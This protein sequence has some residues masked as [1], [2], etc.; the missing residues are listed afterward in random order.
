MTH[1]EMVAVAHEGLLRGPSP[2]MRHHPTAR[3]TEREGVVLTCWGPYG[4][5][6]NKIA[7][8]GP[9]PSLARILEL[10]ETFFSSDAGGFGIV[11]EA[12]AGHAVEAELRAGRYLRMSPR[13]YSQPFPR[14]RRCRSGWR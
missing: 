1:Q 9:S 10:A 14:R 2:L 4:P 8:V 12:D 3:R 6:L 5:A 7:V 13:W 11:V